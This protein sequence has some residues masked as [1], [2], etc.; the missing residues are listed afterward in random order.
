MPK[1]RVHNFTISV[2]GYGAGPD[3]SLDTPLGIGG[4]ELHEW[5]FRTR[6]WH[7]MHGDDGGETGLDDRFMAAGHE[8]IGAFVMGRNMFGPIRGP[9]GDDDWKGWW[10]DNPPYH[11]DVYVLTHH[12]HDPIEMAGGTTFHFVADGPEAALDRA[13]A[14]AGEQDVLIAGGASTI[15]QY[16]RA[17]SI[18]ELHVVISPRLLGRGERLFDGLDTVPDRYDVVD[19]V[20]SPSR[21]AHVRLARKGG[22]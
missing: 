12:D 6:A 3:Q 15:Q 10:G 16:L 1:V 22:G 19:V 21:V 4:E 2:D 5:M 17:G 11:H 18:D 9:W 7:E 20:A 13:R 14:S 8:G